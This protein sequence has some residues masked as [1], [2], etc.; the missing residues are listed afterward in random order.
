MDLHIQYLIDGNGIKTAV[1]IP[2]N[3]WLEFSAEYN[4][5]KQYAELKQGF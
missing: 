4:Y 2:F 1:Q 3:K 5:L